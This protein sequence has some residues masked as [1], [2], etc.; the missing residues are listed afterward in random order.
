MTAKKP[1]ETTAA[2]QVATKPGLIERIGARYGVAGG[3]VYSCLKQT[4]F[5]TKDNGNPVTDEQMM[6]LLIVADQYKLNPFLKEIYAFPD[7]KNGIIPVVGVDGWSH[8]IND[9]PQFDGIEFNYSD[10]IVESDEHSR[11]PEW[12]ECVIHRKDRSTPTNVRE[13]F[14]ECYRAPFEDKKTGYVSKGPWQSH[15]S[16]ILRH[17]ALIQCAR[18]AFGFSGIKDP[19]EAARI[20]ENIT[21]QV[22]V[23]QPS[24]SMPEPVSEAIVEPESPD[25]PPEDVDDDGRLPFDKE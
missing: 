5:S 3:K 17:K 22:D 1:E 21:D 7:K 18:V 6:A 20:V 8:I 9:H 11:C 2:V 24:L 13:W 14:A 25:A 12:I 16:R 4:A 10:S 23:G 19:D 15:T